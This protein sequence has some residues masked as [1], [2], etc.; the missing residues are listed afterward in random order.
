M[1]ALKSDVNNPIW[2]KYKGFVRDNED[3]EN[4]GCLRCYCPQVMGPDDAENSWLGWAEPNFP[5]LG[6]MNTGDFGPPFT[7]EQQ[8]ASFGKEWYGVWLEF[9]MG[10]IDFPIWCGTFTIAPLKNSPSAHQ[11]GT[12]G[13]AS[14]SG[15]GILPTNHPLNPLKADVSREVRLRTPRGVDILIGS[16]DGGGILVGP[17]GVHIVGTQVSINGK[18]HLASSTQKGG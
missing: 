4:R 16:E 10:H 15:G 17:S 9:E 1:P 5:W 6:G 14:M 2:G 8:H 7:R 3:P 12:S 18:V 13:G 11:M